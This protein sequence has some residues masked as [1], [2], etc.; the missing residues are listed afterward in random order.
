MASDHWAACACA[1]IEQD[2]AEGEQKKNQGAVNT[3]VERGQQ[4][5]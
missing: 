4:R 3:K 5:V 2:S 1:Q